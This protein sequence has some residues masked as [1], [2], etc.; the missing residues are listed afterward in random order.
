MQESF[1]SGSD[2]LGVGVGEYAASEVQDIADIWMNDEKGGL[3][4]LETSVLELL[5]PFLIPDLP[6]SFQASPRLEAPEERYSCLG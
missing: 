1:V 5:P 4:V 2:M 3:V 6:C